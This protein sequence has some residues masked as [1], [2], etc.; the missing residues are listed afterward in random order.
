MSEANFGGS[1]ARGNHEVIDYTDFGL[2]EINPFRYRSYYY[3]TETGLYY[4]KSRYYD[5]QTGRFISMD[6]INYLDPETIGGT[7]LYA[8]CNNN[9]VM[10]VDPTGHSA[11]VV[12]LI[13]GL[14]IGAGIGF[15]AAAYIDYSDDGEIFNGS[16]AWYDYLGAIITGGIIGGAIGAGIGYI[17]PAIP[18]ILSSTGSYG[19]ALANGGTATIS[20]TGA[21]IL[22]I[23]SLLGAAIIMFSKNNPNYNSKAPFNWTNKG[24][25]IDAMK[26]HNMD[27][28]KA[29]DDIMNSHFDN[30]HKGAGT[31]HNAIKKWLDRV[32]RKFL[33]G[34]K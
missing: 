14:I 16:V 33:N 15:G 21:Q 25:G 34:G 19:L 1:R 27:A 29:A 31:E 7:N 11:V 12:G 10:Y 6:G 23:A 26:R 4:L 5:P 30:W 9:P 32:I 2:G 24:E 28:H 22:E 17:A 18:S 13:I 8:Y 3:D 20:I